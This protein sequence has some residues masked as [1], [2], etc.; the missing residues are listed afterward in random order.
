MTL[1]LRRSPLSPPRL[2]SFTGSD[3]LGPYFEAGSP[4]RTTRIADAEEPGVRLSLEGRVLAPH[5]HA[6]LAG[7]SLDLWQADVNGKYYSASDDYR[8]RGKITTDRL[9]R[10]R[11]ETVLPG[12]YADDDGIRPAHLHVSFLSPGGNIILTTQLYFAGDPFLGDADYATCARSCNSSDPNR[13]LTLKNGIVA[14]VIGKLATFD[15]VLPT[16]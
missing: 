2:P 13:I 8:L 12:R 9:G 1:S 16:T 5:G 15:A 10:Y 3:A 14:G 4:R 11:F 7:Y 6:V